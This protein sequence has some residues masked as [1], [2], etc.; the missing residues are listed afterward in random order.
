MGNIVRCLYHEELFGLI[1]ESPIILIG[2]GRIAKYIADNFDWN[3]R[4][5]V[6][7]NPQKHGTELVGDCMTIPVYN[8]T[9]LKNNCGE[10]DVLLIT[11]VFVKTFIDQIKSDSS[12]NTHDIYIYSDIWSVQWDIDRIKA[13]QIPFDITR[14]NTNLIPKRIHYFWFSGDLYPEKV[15]RCIDSWH[16][17][18]PDYEFIKWDLKNY[19]TENI[20]CNEALSMRRW[21]FASDYGRCDV[22]YRYGGIYFD[23]DVELV[24]P[25]DDLLYD[26]AF[27]AFESRRGVDPGSG[28]GSVKDN[29]I[30]NEICHQYDEI[31]YINADGSENRVNIL[32]QYTDVLIKHGLKLNGQYQIIDGTAVYPPLV[33]SPY[34]YRTGITSCYEKTYGIHHWVS[35]WLTEEEKQEIDFRKKYISSR[36]HSLL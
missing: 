21:A 5:A 8:W 32:D 23:T 20:F 16:R 14:G 27:F 22:L 17:Y 3:I 26:R 31:H 2:A 11:T 15:K 36:I 1:G 29:E 18:C 28:M 9:Y 12:L 30:F 24:K 34:S 4:Y 25:I 6:D 19:K 35:S 7:N 33:F 13:S 10:G